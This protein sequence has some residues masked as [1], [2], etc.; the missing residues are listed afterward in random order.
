MKA[1]FSFKYIIERTPEG[2]FINGEV[3]SMKLDSIYLI[4]YTHTDVGYT[5]DQ[6]IF[7]EMQ[8]RFIDD[9]LDLIDRYA[10]NPPE[11]C[12]RWS[13]ETTC[14]IDAWLQPAAWALPH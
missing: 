9:A 13:L 8:L 10:G 2:L 1:V 5:N 12:F 14:G 4:D 11:S 3:N 6:P 7:W